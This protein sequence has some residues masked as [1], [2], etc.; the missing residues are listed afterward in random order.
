MAQPEPTHRDVRDAVRARLA[1]IVCGLDGR[2]FTPDAVRPYVVFPETP[3]AEET[4]RTVYGLRPGGRVSRVGVPD[5]CFITVDQTFVLAC[6]RRV[7]AAS[8]NPNDGEPDRWDMAADMADDIEAQIAQDMT[9]EG[10][11][12]HLLDHTIATDFERFTPTW[13]IAEISFTV[14]YRK[15]RPGIHGS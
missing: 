13:A 9:F 7:E 2:N 14:R 8:E 3:V 11:A 6:W 10:K 4:F 12:A 1:A 15:R 5:P